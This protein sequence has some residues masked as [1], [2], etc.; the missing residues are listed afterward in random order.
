M[1]QFPF[2][3][4]RHDSALL[5]ESITG[6]CRR[7]MLATHNEQ[8]KSPINGEITKIQ[9]LKKN[10]ALTKVEDNSYSTQ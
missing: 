6:I 9:S 1:A 5:N 2:L 8:R 7:C 4:S 10:F 3:P